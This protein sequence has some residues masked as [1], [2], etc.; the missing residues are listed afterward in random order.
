MSLGN[1]LHIYETIYGMRCRDGVDDP[2]WNWKICQGRGA[3]S[4]A[5]TMDCVLGQAR[6][7]GH[8]FFVLYLDLAQ[9]FP[10]IQRVP[11]HFPAEMFNGL[12]ED[13][14]LL[15]RAVFDR[16]RARF[17]TAF[18]LGAEFTIETGDLMGGV[19]SPDHARMLLTA[20]SSGL[21]LKTAGWAMKRAEGSGAAA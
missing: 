10:A 16:T 15:S 19:L 21:G 8:A 17:D 11:R 3:L 1:K 13:V 12:P 14:V 9:F 18:G 5:L 20:T 4:A 7:L 6:E 2:G